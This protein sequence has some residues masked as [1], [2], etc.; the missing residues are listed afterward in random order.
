[1]KSLV[2]YETKYGNTQKV[3]ETVAET[4]G[5]QAYN[6]QDFD[7]AL[8]GSVDL[9]VMGSPIHGWQP[10]AETAQFLTH[11]DGDELKGKYIAAFDTGFK[12]FMSGN[13]ASKIVRKLERAGAK[14][15]IP[16]RKFVVEQAEGPLATGELDKARAW[17]NELKAEYE[18]FAAP[19]KHVVG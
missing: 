15:L 7:L 6:V 13:A 11:L 3:A 14:Q 8:L 1:M 16:P 17:A 18:R 4:L 10:S 2:L 19:L 5:G 12:S 9:L